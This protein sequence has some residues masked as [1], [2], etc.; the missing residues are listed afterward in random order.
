MLAGQLTSKGRLERDHGRS[1]GASELARGAVLVADHKVIGAGSTSDRVVAGVS[2]HTSGECG[3]VA[4]Q[5]VVPVAAVDNVV[6]PPPRI[7]APKLSRADA[8]TRSTVGATELSALEVTWPALTS[9]N[10]AKS[11]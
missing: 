1:T 2:G 3:V 4:D 10:E 8:V 5:E 7:S 6:A 11:A 9:L